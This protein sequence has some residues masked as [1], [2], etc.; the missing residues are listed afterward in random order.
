[1]GIRVCTY[2]ME[3]FDDAFS[4]D[5]KLR[6]EAKWQNKAAAIAEVVKTV[7]PDLITVLEAPGTTASSGKSTVAAWLGAMHR[8]TRDQGVKL[9]LTAETQAVV[10]GSATELRRAVT[11]LVVNALKYAP[12]GTTVWVSKSLRSV[13]S[14]ALMVPPM[15]AMTLSSKSCVRGRGW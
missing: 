4:P 6:P 12:A 5:N 14:T 10:R 13:I 1:M 3:W 9:L 2:N 11:N 15:P 7:D 8:Q